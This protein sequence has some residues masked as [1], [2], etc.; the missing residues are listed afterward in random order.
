[1]W[2]CTTGVTLNMIIMLF[3]AGNNAVQAIIQIK[4]TYFERRAMQISRYLE[5]AR[6]SHVEKSFYVWPNSLRSGT[7][8]SPNTPLV[9]MRGHKRAPPICT[10]IGGNSGRRAAKK[11]RFNIDYLFQKGPYCFCEARKEHAVGTNLTAGFYL[12]SNNYSHVDIRY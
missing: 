7:L 1:M 8:A 11:M 4:S 5:R 2:N 10:N 9:G 6:C 12:L 3:A